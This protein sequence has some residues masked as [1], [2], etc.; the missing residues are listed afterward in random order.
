MGTK[1]VDDLI[2]LCGLHKELC[3]WL[4]DADPANKRVLWDKL[5]DPDQNVQIS[6]EKRVNWALLL[7]LKTTNDP[8]ILARLAWSFANEVRAKMSAVSQAGMDSIRRFCEGDKFVDIQKVRRE[9]WAAAANAA[10]WKTWAADAAA[11]SA[12]WGADAAYDAAAD[13]AVY[14]ATCAVDSADAMRRRQLEIIR[15]QVKSELL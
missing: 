11:Y 8:R 6:A 5:L 10:T 7:I 3:Y 2:A 12:T 9:L 13:A 14:A 4:R 15:E 1:F